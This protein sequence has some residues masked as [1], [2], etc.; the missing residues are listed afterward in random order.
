L[1]ENLDDLR[2]GIQQVLDQI[3]Q[4]A[5]D[6]VNRLETKLQES[7]ELAAQLAEEKQ[8]LASF[9]WETLFTCWSPS[10]GGVDVLTCVR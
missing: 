1:S 10:W 3:S 9:C 2:K 6:K 7:Q 5:K 4:P 8:K